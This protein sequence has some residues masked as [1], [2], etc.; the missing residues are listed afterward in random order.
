MH[1][2]SLIILFVF[3]NIKCQN[4]ISPSFELVLVGQDHLVDV[5]EILIKL[6]E[7]VVALRVVEFLNLAAELLGEHVGADVFVQ[8][9]VVGV[10]VDAVLGGHII[11]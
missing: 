6:H 2:V 5:L 4:I 10:G 8:F 7:G 9:P 1:A 3:S 11:C